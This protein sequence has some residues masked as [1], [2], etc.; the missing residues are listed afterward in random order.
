MAKRHQP[1][2]A[3]AYSIPR[4]VENHP[5]RMVDRARQ[6]DMLRLA[7]VVALLLVGL[8]VVAGLHSEWLALGYDVARLE[9][10]RAASEA[11]QRH[12]R[13]ELETLRAPE[14]IERLALQDLNLVAPS[15]TEAV[16]LERVRQAAAPARTLVARRQAPEGGVGG[17]E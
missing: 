14:R 2:D 10:A 7:G 5:V 15:Q 13:L 4:E 6:R 12:L 11:E 16:V 3:I 9:K 8:L 17:H 1:A